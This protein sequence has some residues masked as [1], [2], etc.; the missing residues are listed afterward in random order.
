MEN[1]TKEC[2]QYTQYVVGTLDASLSG[3]MLAGKGLI[4]IGDG[5]I[6]PGQDF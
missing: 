5:V 1:E 6:R 3:N 2:M 4:R